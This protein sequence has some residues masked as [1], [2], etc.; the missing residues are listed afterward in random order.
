MD[1]AV[2]S[3]IVMMVF[4]CFVAEIFISKLI[5]IHIYKDTIM[6]ILLTA[7]F[8]VGSWVI[9]GFMG[10]LIYIVAFIIYLLINKK[11]IIHTVKSAKEIM[12]S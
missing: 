10:L 1:I 12:F 9:G 6:E 8:I 7:T 2:A 11:E 4:K 3:I 5:N